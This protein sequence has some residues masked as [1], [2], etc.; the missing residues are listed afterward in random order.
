MKSKCISLSLKGVEGV[1]LTVH[2]GLFNGHIVAMMDGTVGALKLQLSC[3]SLRLYQRNC[4][5]SL[6]QL[7]VPV[8][9]AALISASSYRQS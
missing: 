5:K 3:L 6:Q 4:K 7:F 9:A 8:V 2:R 1:H